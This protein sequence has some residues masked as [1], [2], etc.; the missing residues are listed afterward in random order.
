M[1]YIV[2]YGEQCSTGLNPEELLKRLSIKYCFLYEGTWN[3]SRN[4][5]KYRKMNIFLI[6]FDILK[7]HRFLSSRR[8]CAGLTEKSIVDKHLTVSYSSNFEVIFT[9]LFSTTPVN[10]SMRV[11]WVIVLNVTYGI[12]NI[13]V[14]SY[15]EVIQRS[16]KAKVYLLVI[17]LA[18][19]FIM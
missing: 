8:K 7:L 4:Q 13:K 11:P 19:R 12:F 1:L 9:L 5:I 2:G 14:I 16:N 18:W 10:I 15:A 17:F 3:M 6:R